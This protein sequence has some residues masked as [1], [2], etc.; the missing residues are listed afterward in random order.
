MKKLLFSFFI[1]LF[2]PSYLYS[3]SLDEAI[4][5]ALNNNPE[6]KTAKFKYE[7]AKAKIPQ[8]MSLSDPWFIYKA[9]AEMD[10]RDPAFEITQEIPFPTKLFSR[11]K[12]SDNEAKSKYEEYREKEKEV[13]AKVKTAYAK[14][15][16]A[17]KMIEVNKEV[18]GLLG[19]AS[20]SATNRYSIGKAGQQDALKAQIELAKVDAN[21]ITWE[22]KRQSANAKLNILLNYSPENNIG[23]PELDKNSGSINALDDLYNL[24]KQSRSELKAMRY[25]IDKAKTSLNLAGQD[26]LPDFMIS[27]ERMLDSGEDMWMI[28]ASVPVWFFM[29][30]NYGVKEMQSDLAMAEY[31]YKNAENM[32]LFDIKDFYSQFDSNKKL[33]D[34]YETA[35]LPQADQSF[36]SSLTAYE[37]GQENFQG[38][39][40]SERTILELKMEYYE[41]L[42]NLEIAMAELERTV[43]I[44]FAEVEK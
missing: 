18:R 6:I 13:L 10:M 17:Y 12:V 39:L 37:S 30:Q 36:K 29:K 19:Q 23:E 44:N 42:M 4:Q 22:Q 3:I 34:L 5:T 9:D 26:Y 41:V 2:F 28:G 16:L 15:Y 25:M 40:D 1:V 14:L 24:A 35:L 38:L 32:V 20:D 33:K 11:G 27:Y 31:E 7:S 21:L 8:S 43:G